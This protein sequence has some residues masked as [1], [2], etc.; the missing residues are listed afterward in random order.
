MKEAFSDSATETI[1]WPA[2]RDCSTRILWLIW[3]TLKDFSAR[4]KMQANVDSRLVYSVNCGREKMFNARR[5]D[6]YWRILRMLL[7]VEIGLKVYLTVYCV[8]YHDAHKGEI[9]WEQ[10]E[11]VYRWLQNA[12]HR[13]TADYSTARFGACNVSLITRLFS[14]RPSSAWQKIEMFCGDKRRVIS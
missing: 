4:K 14:W 10:Y 12:L 7:F 1:P 11:Q 3:K 6:V 13:I 2:L 5:H 8:C 9:N